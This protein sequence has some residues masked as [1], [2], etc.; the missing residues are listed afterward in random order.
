MDPVSVFQPVCLT[1]A[2]AEIIRSVIIV[3]SAQATRPAF[4]LLSHSEVDAGASIPGQR[5]AKRALHQDVVSESLDKHVMNR[6]G[7]SQSIA[8]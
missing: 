6:L 8:T 3:V 5:E 4:V 1:V 2:A 7:Q